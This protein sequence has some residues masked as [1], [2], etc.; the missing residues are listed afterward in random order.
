M[1]DLTPNV[2]RAALLLV[3]AGIAAVL[4]EWPGHSPAPTALGEQTALALAEASFESPRGPRAAELAEAHHRQ[5]AARLQELSSMHALGKIN[6]HPDQDAVPTAIPVSQQSIEQAADKAAT[7]LVDQAFARA[8]V[9]E[10]TLHLLKCACVQRR[11]HAPAAL[12]SGIIPCS[13]DHT[14][15]SVA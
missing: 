4:V 14:Q 5:S 13:D 6:F 11:A 2:G 15:L 8:M 3:L 12:A 7:K 10:H 9:C 1:P